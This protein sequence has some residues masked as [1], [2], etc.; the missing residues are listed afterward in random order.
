MSEATAK[1]IDPVKNLHIASRFTDLVDEGINTAKRV[2]KQTSDAVEELMDDTA[3]RIKRHPIETVAGAFA[4]GLVVGGFLC[5][6]TMLGWF[7]RRK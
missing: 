7:M 2:G 4:A 6:L 3:L 1:V 5:S